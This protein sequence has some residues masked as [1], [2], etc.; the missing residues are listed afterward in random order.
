MKIEFKTEVVVTSK[1]GFFGEVLVEAE[2]SPAF[3]P[4]FR[5][6]FLVGKSEQPLIGQVIQV[7]IKYET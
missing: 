7:E 2:S 5:I 1:D 4:N 6:G 3:K